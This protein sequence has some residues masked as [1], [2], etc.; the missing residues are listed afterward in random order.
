MRNMRILFCGTHPEQFNGYS[1]VV[2]ELSN[3]ISKYDDIEWYIYGFQ[4]FYDSHQHKMERTL[5]SNVKIYDA[6]KHEE[7]KGKGFGENEFKEHVLKINPDIVIIYNDLIIIH[8][9]LTKL[10]EIQNRTFKIIPYIDIV[11]K[12]EKNSLIQKIQEMSDGGIM[13]TE[14]WKEVIQSQGWT[15]PLWIL[16]H[17]FNEKNYFQIPKRLSRKFFNIPEDAFVIVNLNRNQPRKRWDICLMSFI[18]FISCHLD[19]DIRLM[20]STTLQGSWDLVDIMISECKKYNISINDL[21]KHLILIKNPQQ[22]TDYD[23]NIMYNVGDIG[24]NTCD[25][26]GF[27]LCN[28]EQ[29]GVG[30]PQ[31]VPHIGGFKDFFNKDNSLLI[32]SKWS[33]YCDH[34]RDFVSGEAEVCD[35][36]DYVKALNFYHENKNVVKAHG[37]N[38]K[39]HICK[40][41]K[42]VDKGKQLYRIINDIATKF[43]INKITVDEID[44]NKLIDD[45]LKT[46]NINPNT[47]PNIKS[48]IE[49][50]EIDINKLIDEKLKSNNMTETEG[51]I[52]NNEI[53]I[54]KLID[55]KKKTHE[56]LEGFDVQKM[57]EMYK[58]LQKILNK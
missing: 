8:T 6:F 51:D 20:I 41:Y 30:V 18:K 48:D 28:F 45:K 15:K 22:L 34:S 33:F 1:K 58:T 57:E 44:I 14:H 32:E 42:W 7:P 56:S 16:E 4:N 2:Y 26:E 13:F 37:K 29:A 31:I 54:N 24:W 49:N 43:D 19:K 35:I 36:N 50:N 46:I 25:G 47:N 40:N 17:G 9:L 27:G 10:H 3:E 38:A 12:N 5:P 21:Q 53:D 23:I 52:E 11:Y 39:E 55:E